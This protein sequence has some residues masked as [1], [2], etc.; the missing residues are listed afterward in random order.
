MEGLKDDLSRGYDSVTGTFAK[1]IDPVKEEKK[2]LPVYDGT[3]PQASV[4]QDLAHL[5][6]FTDDS[7]PSD[8]TMI[9]EL[10][11]AAIHNTCRTENGTIV[12]QI[13]LELAGRT[14]PKGRMQPGDKPSFAYPYFVAVTDAQGNVLS[15]EIFAASVSYGKDQTQIQQ[16]ENIFQNMPFPDSSSGETYA[17]IVGFQLTAEQLTYNQSHPRMATGSSPAAYQ[18]TGTANN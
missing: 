15:K 18:A 1:A 13:D 17:V 10:E 12:M 4:R 16:S 11:I 8:G 14:G 7:K 3:C 5:T 6:E 9:S 2:K